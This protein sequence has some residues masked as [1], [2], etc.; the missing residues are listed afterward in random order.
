MLFIQF[1]IFCA[2]LIALYFAADYLQKPR[3][4][5]YD[6]HMESQDDERGSV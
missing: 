1:V 3:K 5:R 4:P 6:P 2:T